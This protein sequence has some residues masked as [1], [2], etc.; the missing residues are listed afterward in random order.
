MLFS[1][2]ELLV[3][4]HVSSN[5]VIVVSDG[6]VGRKIDNRKYRTTSGQIWLDDVR[7]DGTETNIAACSHNDWGVHNCRHSEDVALWC[8]GTG[9]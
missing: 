3:S 9:A 6:S 1:V 8:E 4:T 5:A 2:A 7:C